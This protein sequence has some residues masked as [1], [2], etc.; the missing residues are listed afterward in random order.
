M[1][2]IAEYEN[3]IFMLNYHPFKQIATLD[4][5]YHNHTTL[6]INLQHANQNRETERT[7]QCLLPELG[8]LAAKNVF[9]K[10]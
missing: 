1:L 2:K 5:S 7:A 9:H 6:C 10:G 4:K 3:K 8:Q